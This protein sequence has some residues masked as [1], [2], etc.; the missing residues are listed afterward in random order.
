MRRAAVAIVATAVA[1]RLVY[2]RGTL[3][4]DAAWALVW[5]NEL[6]DGPALDAPGAP[7]PHPLAILVSAVIA[8]LGEAGIEVVL[9]LSWLA[10][11]AVGWFAFRLGAV[12][13]SP[14]VGGLFAALLL[15]RPLLVLE[16]GQAVIDIP[17]LALVLAAMTAEARNPRT[18]YAVP[19]L[20]GLAGLLRPEAWLLAVAWAA[21]A[22]RPS[23]AIALAAPLLWIA[24]DF[25]ATGDP[26]HSLHGT[27]ALAAELERPRE[28]E[29][30]LRTTPSYL[31]AAL[32]EPVIWLGLA[33]C[34]LAITRL[35]ERTMLPAAVAGL[36]L[37]AF[38]V[39]G[40][41]GLPLLS[42]YL[43]LPAA[44]LTLWCAVAA[45]GFTVAGGTVWRVAAAVSLA[46]LAFGLPALRDELRRV[47][48][49]VDG[50]AEVEQGFTG[51]LTAAAVQAEL[52]RCGGLSV[53]DD[54]PY[55][56]ARLLVEE[57]ITIRGA[58]APS[59][60]ATAE[61]R[62]VYRIGPAPPPGLPLGS[63]ALAATPTTVAGSCAR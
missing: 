22:R 5:G 2:G 4:Y 24:F 43:L 15:T 32:T 62:A 23:A 8:P 1:A 61:A 51:V 6:F 27:Q 56:L 35:Q 9:A 54:R 33:G 52:G 26:L 40:A 20:L 46:V 50:R 48:A 25:A 31:R 13:Y 29:T 36:G 3:G 63:R 14:W 49:I 60:Y 59:N 42:R 18:G 19:V 11:G 37:L 45:L 41:T 12:L 58:G 30:A 53:P 16:A 47:D 38:L 28:L 55:P 10:F 34:A 44:M 57:P 21:W 17:F 7:T 39:L